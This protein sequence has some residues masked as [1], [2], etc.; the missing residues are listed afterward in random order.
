MKGRDRCRNHGGAS[1]GPLTS[2]G[3]ARIAAAQTTHGRL[4]KEK[5]AEVKRNAKVGRQIRAELAEIEAWAV[6]RGHL[7]QDWR[8]KLS[9]A[10]VLE[11]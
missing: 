10:L 7:E 2:E 1:T 6:G 5:R 8:E 4:M 3:R 11:S 9:K